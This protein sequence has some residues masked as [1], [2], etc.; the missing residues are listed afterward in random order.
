MPEPPMNG[1]GF[2][3]SIN[4]MHLIDEHAKYLIFVNHLTQTFEWS[5]AD[6]E[7]RAL[8][9]WGWPAEKDSQVDR[10]NA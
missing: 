4:K 9:R 10:L 3:H 5:A 2:R 7:N 6:G 8:P 1:D